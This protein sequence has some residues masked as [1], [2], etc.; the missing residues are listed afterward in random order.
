L[1]PILGAKVCSAATF[2]SAGLV[3]G[4]RVGAFTGQLYTRRKGHVTDA[5]ADDNDDDDDVTVDDVTWC[6]TW[7]ESAKLGGKKLGK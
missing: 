7:G 4:H 1:S 3:L 2:Y 5:P 6:A